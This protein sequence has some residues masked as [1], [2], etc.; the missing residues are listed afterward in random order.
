MAGSGN[1][2]IDPILSA[3]ARLMADPSFQFAWEAPPPLPP[4]PSW[5]VAVLRVIGHGLEVASPFIKFGLW[6]LLIIAAVGVALA[7]G[8]QLL[9]PAGRNQRPASHSPSSP[10]NASKA[11][12]IAIARLEEADRLAAEGL[13]ADAAHVLLL[14]GVADVEHSRAAGI[15]T[16]LTTREIAA[17]PDFP[18]RPRA[19][20]ALI[21]RVAEHALFGGAQIDADRWITCRAAYETLVRPEAWTM[22]PSGLAR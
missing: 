15:Q 11:A 6:G 19:A 10:A 1:A 20:F 16:S 12:E 9:I 17:L 5:F 21:A 3:H 14:R 13:Y 2:V 4:P 22:P 8:R 18:P 7:L